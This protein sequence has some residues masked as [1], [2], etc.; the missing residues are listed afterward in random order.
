MKDY[1]INC[2]ILKDKNTLI[3][4]YNYINVRYDVSVEINDIK[5]EL[6]KLITPFLI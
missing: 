1:I 3:D 2:F 6:I 4:I 5:I